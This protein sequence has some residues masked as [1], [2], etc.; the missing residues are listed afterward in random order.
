MASSLAPPTLPEKL[1]AM[2]PNIMCVQDPLDLAH[3]VAKSVSLQTL[4]LFTDMVR[5]GAQVMVSLLESTAPNSGPLT[6]LDL[7]KLNE[8]VMLDDPQP[9]STNSQLL[10]FSLDTAARFLSKV[11][12]FADLT[13]L[14]DTIDFSSQSAQD[15]LSRVVFR[16]LVS[17]LEGLEFKCSEVLS[18]DNSISSDMTTSTADGPPDLCHQVSERKRQRD[19]SSNSSEEDVYRD[20]PV[21]LKRPKCLATPVPSRDLLYQHACREDGRKYPDTLLC[22]A[23]SR[24]WQNRRQ[25]RRHQHESQSDATDLPVLQFTMSITS[26]P[27]TPTSKDRKA[28]RTMRGSL[29]FIQMKTADQYIADFHRF[30]AFFKKFIFSP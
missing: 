2:K 25:A 18:T 27:V 3:N 6:I 7:F 11:P 15:N 16:A 1:R 26:T 13:S 24:T 4:S 29:V 5:K 30:F 22:T 20:D 8:S 10:Y 19:L 28:I 12:Q 23:F 17:H 14:M 9:H 21:Q